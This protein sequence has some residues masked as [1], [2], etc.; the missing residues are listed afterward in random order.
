[1]LD[2]AG[3]DAAE[4]GLAEALQGLAAEAAA[5]EAADGLVAR[6]G[7][8]REDEVEAHAELAGPGEEAALREGEDAG[9]DSEDEALRQRVEDA[10]LADVHPAVPL[11]RAHQPIAEADLAAELHRVGAGR[12]EGVGAGVEHAAVAALGEDAAA[13]ARAGLQHGD[14]ERRA[15]RVPAGTE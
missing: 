11:D 15:P 4:E 5:E 13:E 14:D 12:D 1:R 9:R 2:V 7:A 8:A 3:V 10:A 6:V